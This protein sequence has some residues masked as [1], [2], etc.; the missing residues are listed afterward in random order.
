MQ[1]K[2]KN[3]N[4]VNRE[5]TTEEIKRMDLGFE[6]LSIEEGVEA[7][8]SDRLSFVALE[9]NT[10]IGCSSGLAYKNGEHY[11]GWFFLTDLFVEKAYRSKGLGATLLK[12]T[13]EQAVSL[14]LK[15]IWLWTSG[16]KALR[17]YHRHAYK[18]FVEMENWYSDGSS[19]VGLRKEL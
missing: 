4:I 1:F 2:M 8:S 19:R 10:F 11:S 9:E 13:E 7:E 3:I 14:G 15:H 5:M 6:E 16:E 12:K 17:F 18:N